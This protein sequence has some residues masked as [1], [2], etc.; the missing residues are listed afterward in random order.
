MPRPFHHLGQF[1]RRRPAC[2]GAPASSGYVRRIDVAFNTQGLP[3]LFTDYADPYAIRTLDQVRDAYNGLGQ[4]T[5]EYQ[6]HAGPVNIAVT[7]AVR[8][9]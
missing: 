1:R 5:A 6:S 3:A 9:S 8:Y 4:V 7:P 2:L